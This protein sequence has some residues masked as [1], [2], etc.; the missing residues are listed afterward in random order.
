MPRFVRKL[1][2]AKTDPLDQLALAS[3]DLY[4]RVVVYFWRTV[5]K[6]GIWLSPNALMKIFKSD[7]LHSQSAQATIQTFC[8][9]LKSWRVRRKVDPEAKPPRR[10]RR[11]FKVIWKGQAIQLRDGQLILPNG[12]GNEPYTLKWRFDKPKQVEMGW[13]GQSYELRATYVTDESA[14]QIS[15]DG[16]A[17]VDLGEIHPATTFDSTESVIYNGR[18]LRSKKQYQNKLKAR[19]ASRIDTK[20]KG[21][22]RWRRLVKAKKRHLA[23]IQNQIRD[24]EHKQSRALVSTL[25]NA[26]VQTLVIGDV[27]DI[28]QG[29]DYG[30]RANQ[31][32]HQWC[33]G[34]FRHLITYKWEMLGGEVA[35]QDEA[36][37]S[38]TCPRCEDRHKPKGRTFKC[39][40]GFSAHR[41]CV[42]AINIL[43]KYQGCGPVV[44][45]MAPPSRGVRYHPHLVCRSEA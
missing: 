40:C 7:D 15:G 33:H 27:R 16:I 30:K 9:S 44:G 36:Y 41:D 25:L 43:Q 34:R 4:S 12:R 10:G 45:D 2:V 23:S 26:R 19:L 3:G 11:F 31:K 6:K 21:S 29:L 42:G 20:K 18:L 24:I 14:T 17:A 13:N 37:T 38:S 22:R 5:R 39:R 8:A 28:R 35:L 1:K 32:L